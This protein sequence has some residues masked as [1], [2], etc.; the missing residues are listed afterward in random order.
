MSI[1]TLAQAK[2]QLG[3]DSFDTS[4]DAELQEYV[5][6]VTGAVEEYKHEVIE[7]RTITDEIEVHGSGWD[8]RGGRK[9]RLWS[10]PVISLTSVVSWDSTI[11]WD[12]SQM[13]VSS[14]GLVRVMAGLP[15]RGLVDVTYV[16]GYETV[17][18][19]YVRGALVILEHVWETQRGIGTAEAGVIGPEEIHM[20]AGSTFTVPN[21]A[22]EWLGAP[23][24][25]VA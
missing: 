13:R 12:V 10:A 19:R 11:T 20:R 17:P 15:V 21:K 18:L 3:I 4:D 6:A 14:S 25:L 2:E 1:V 24:V 7:Q 8:W 23:R 22:R 16:A 9:F 5:D